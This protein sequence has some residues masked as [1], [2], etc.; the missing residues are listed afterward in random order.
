MVGCVLA[1]PTFEKEKKKKRKIKIL[2]IY[3]ALYFGS[4]FNGRRYGWT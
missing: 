1:I 2:M 4:F 3:N